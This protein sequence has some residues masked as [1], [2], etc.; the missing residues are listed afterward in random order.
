MSRRIVLL[1]SL[2]PGLVSA[3]GLVDLTDAE[4]TRGLKEALLQ[5]AERAVVQLG[6]ENGF[7]SNAKVHIPLPDSLARLDATLRRFGASRHSEELI[8][9]MNRAAEAAVPEARGLLLEAAE[10][11]TI[12]D[13]KDILRGGD[14]AATVYFRKQS[15]A[16]LGARFEPVV[17]RATEQVRLAS[18]YNQFAGR[19]AKYGLIR[20]EDADLNGY[21]T[22]KALDG[23]Y[24]TIAEEERAIR[25]SPMQ[26]T[27]RLLRTVFG[28]S[29]SSTF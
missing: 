10:R 21:V 13:A 12:Q 15:E 3:A 7:L 5:G 11:M 8:T 2:W 24:L 22:R 16:A 18:A 26:Q 29:A 4:V 25:H 6:R 27:R 14:D 19:A 20:V 28:A 17:K 23:L 1:A 9:A